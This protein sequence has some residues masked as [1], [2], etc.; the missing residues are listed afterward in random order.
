MVFARFDVR[1]DQHGIEAIVSGEPLDEA[2]HLIDHEVKA[3][4]YHELKIQQN[5]NGWMAEVIVDI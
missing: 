5:D 2:R 1:L 3:V 4:T